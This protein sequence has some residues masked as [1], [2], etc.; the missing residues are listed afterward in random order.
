MLVQ[1]GIDRAINRAGTKDFW[2]L[3]RG[4][5]LRAQTRRY[6]A[7]F[8]C[9]NAYRKSRAV[10]F[11]QAQIGDDKPAR[12]QGKPVVAYIRPMHLF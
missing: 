4:H 5:K 2:K 7:K 11:R 10:W 1:G 3:S 8:S 9:S 12:R 6:V